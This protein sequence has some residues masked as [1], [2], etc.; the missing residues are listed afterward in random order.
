MKNLKRPRKLENASI[1]ALPPR[2]LTQVTGGLP[3]SGVQPPVQHGIAFA[4][5]AYMD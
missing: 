3:S 4:M 1:R 2:G 5:N